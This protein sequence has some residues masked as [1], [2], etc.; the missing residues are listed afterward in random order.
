MFSACEDFDASLEES[1]TQNPTP[2]D[3]ATEA[4]A[5]S[6]FQ[7]WYFNS[8]AYNGPGLMLTTMA[9]MNTCP[10][11]N[12]AMQDMSSEPRAAWS[13]DPGYSNAVALEEYYANMYSLLANQTTLITAM[14]GGLE[15]SDP[16]KIECLAR[17]GQAAAIGYLALVFDQVWIVDETGLLFEGEAGTPEQA[18]EIALEKL[19]IAIELAS[20]N[21]FTVDAV[22]GMTLS[23]SQW[24]EFLNTLG[25]RLLANVARNS[26]QR[27]NTDWPRVLT[28][29]NNGLTYDLNVLSDGWINWA[30][31]WSLYMTYSGWGRVDMRVVNLMDPSM[32]SKWTSTSGYLPEATS[33]DNRLATDF[34][35]LDSQDFPANRGIY[36]YS[37]YRHSRY[38]SETHLIEYTGSVP[39]MLK[40]ENDLYK[41]EAILRSGGSVSDAVSVINSSSRVLRGG[42]TP[43]SSGAN[44]TTVYDAINYERSVE[45]Q[46]I[47]LGLGF[48]NMRKNDL[49][50]IG[51]PLHLPVPGSYLLAGGYDNYTFGGV[52]NADG[53]NVS[54]GGW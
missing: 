12:A 44:A 50:Q 16:A 53:I 11:G 4:T 33:L 42:L 49:L 8:N 6:A 13:N 20:N 17:F 1:Y 2:E 9:D 30:T 29:A 36:H 10:W 37:N 35:Y 47:G 54:N 51:T 14:E 24:A 5:I 27:D 7:S 25:A 15:V 23:S 32:P 28:Y 22:N 52:A 3:I 31:E 45:L 48:F 18:M 39:E 43:L 40:A 21:S 34:Q 38:D 26:T 41:A 19:D 46:S